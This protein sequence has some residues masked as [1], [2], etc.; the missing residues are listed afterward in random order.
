MNTMDH[1]YHWTEEF[2]IDDTDARWKTL[3]VYPK[4]VFLTVSLATKIERILIEA[5]HEKN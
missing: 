2:P 5:L 4:L 3:F 1:M